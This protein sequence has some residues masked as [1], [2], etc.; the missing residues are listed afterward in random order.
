MFSRPV[1]LCHLICR[2]RVGA[3]VGGLRSPSLARHAAQPPSQHR[4]DQAHKRN[5]SIGLKNDLEHLIDLEPFFD[6]AINECEE[7]T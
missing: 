7:C 3:H 4:D 6:W 1:L 5:L 2:V